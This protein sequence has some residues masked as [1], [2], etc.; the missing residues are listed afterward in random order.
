MV[1]E[2]KSCALCPRRCGIDRTKAKGRCGES[3][4]IRIARAALH[5]WEEPCI[6]GKNGSGAVFFS[7]CPLG[8]DYCQNAAISR[9][10]A[11]K[12]VS[13]ARLAEI[14]RELEEKG[15]HN[16]NLVTPTH[17]AP[18]IIE[19]LELYRPKI[20]IVYNCGGYESP[21][22]VKNLNGYVDV[23]L[24]DIKYFSDEYAVKYSRAPRYFEY[25]FASLGEMLAQTG[26]PRLEGG[27]LKSGVIVRHLCLPG[28]RRD[29]MSILE[30]LAALPKGSF[31]LSLMSQYLPMGYA[32]ELNRRVTSFEYNSVVKRAVEL[33]LTE[34]YTQERSS[35][36]DDFIPE[37]NGEGV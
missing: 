16:I 22:A 3:A 30:R 21:E 5:L 17:F 27:L 19:A 35:A 36:R 11:G 1:S 23:Y 6:S 33:G 15:A 13:A 32:P 26:E 4:E 37:F 7:G 34:G 8:C 29:S 28:L 25:A 24:T 12:A 14:F 2:Y 31:L 20:P 9:G 10:G 18:S